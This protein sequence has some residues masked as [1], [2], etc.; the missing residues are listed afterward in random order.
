MT[1]FE[2][3]DKNATN[4]KGTTVANIPVACTLTQEEFQERKGNH[5]QKL[6]ASLLETVERPE[7]YAFRFPSELFDDLA[8][9]VSLER[10]CCSFLRFSLTSEPGGG[11]VWLEITGPDDS[12]AFLSTFWE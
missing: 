6:G 8:H 10:R 11:P 9:V 3:Q 12:K 5:L 2:E 7:G 1:T 4:P